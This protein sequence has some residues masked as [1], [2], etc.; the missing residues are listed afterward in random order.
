MFVVHG[1][2][3]RDRGDGLRRQ[4]AY[5]GNCPPYPIEAEALMAGPNVTAAEPPLLP[6]QKEKGRTGKNIAR[7]ASFQIYFFSAL[8]LRFQGKLED[9][10]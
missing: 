2:G 4:E 1:D 7:A 5:R 3:R 9:A 6:G 10:R 8:E